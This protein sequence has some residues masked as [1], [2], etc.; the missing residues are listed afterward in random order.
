MPTPAPAA[1]SPARRS[2]ESETEDRMTGR[3]AKL[4]A[5]AIALLLALVAM[6]GMCE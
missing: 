1:G 4:A 3:E 6:G 2:G 5:A